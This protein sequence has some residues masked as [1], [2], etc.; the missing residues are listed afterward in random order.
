MLD[1]PAHLGGDLIAQVELLAAGQGK[2]KP[3]VLMLLQFQVQCASKDAACHHTGS[4]TTVPAAMPPCCMMH[5][6]TQPQ[7]HHTGCT[8]LKSPSAHAGQGEVRPVSV[9]LRE[10][11]QTG[12]QKLQ[13]RLFWVRTVRR[14][15]ATPTNYCCCIAECAWGDGRNTGGGWGG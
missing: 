4:I 12:A 11:G 2:Q 5:H 6:G 13:S 7:A 9:L 8:H 3:C 14:W 10:R 1:S 15:R